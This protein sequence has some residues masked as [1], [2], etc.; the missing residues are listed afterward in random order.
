MSINRR[1]SNKKKEEIYNLIYNI[2]LENDVCLTSTRYIN[3]NSPL[4]FECLSYKNIF[5]D[6]WINIKKRKN[7]KLKC[8]YCYPQKSKSDYYSE[9]KA[10]VESKGGVLLSKKYVNAK[11]KVSIQC[12]NGHT[13]SI[14]PNDIKNGYWCKECYIQETRRQITQEIREFIESKGGILKNIDF[15]SKKTRVYVECEN[16]H[17]WWSTTSSIKEGK[18]CKECYLDNELKYLRLKTFIESKGGKLL[19]NTYEG[20]K[21]KLEVECEVGHKWSATPDNLLNGDTWCPKC[22]FQIVADLFKKYTLTAPFDSKCERLNNNNKIA[23]VLSN[24]LKKIHEMEYPYEAFSGNEHRA[25]KL[26]LIGSIP[27]K[28]DLTKIRNYF[29][30]RKVLKILDRFYDY[31]LMLNRFYSSYQKLKKTNPY[32]PPI[33]NY[34]LENHQYSVAIEVPVWRKVKNLDI[35]FTGHIDLL[36]FHN[37]TIIIMD[38]K[39][40]QRQVINSIPQVMVYGLMMKERLIDL[41]SKLDYNITCALL[42]KDISMI[43]DPSLIFNHV[44]E[45]T[46]S[47][48]YLI[49]KMKGT[50]LYSDLIRYLL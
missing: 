5:F 30:G 21:I 50:S 17:F 38:L 6:Q 20:A 14:T 26:K 29:Y 16:H 47:N 3:R 7:Q 41:N 22:H 10:I 15:S 42:T 27:H 1:E 18:W 12:G 44:L 31:M 11:T 33:L 46:K 40:N 48:L 34:F 25:S 43:F 28:A 4:M 8:P 39:Q 9:L 37:N 2:A 36:A 13:W 24:Y 19:S 49:G 35:Y 23:S 32:H 45:Y